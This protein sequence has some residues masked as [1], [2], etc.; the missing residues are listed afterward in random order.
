MSFIVNLSN[1]VY[2]DAGIKRAEEYARSRNLDPSKFRFPWTV[3][4]S[5][6][7]IFKGNTEKYPHFLFTDTLFIPI[8][9]I[10]DP[11]QLV[12][13]EMRYLGDNPN[14]T[15]YMKIKNSSD[16]FPLYFTQDLH[17]IPQDTPVIVTEGVMDAESIRDLGMPIISPLT[18]LQG[19]KWA[20]FLYAVSKKVF[21]AYDNDAGGLKAKDN[22]L[23]DLGEDN[24][25][26]NS[27]KLLSYPGK[28]L[29]EAIKNFGKRTILEQIKNQLLKG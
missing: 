6:A 4:G 22:F 28:D 15:R 27:F 10:E 25:L 21:I 11:T 24:L 17:T 20:L 18:A 19:V 12:A 29:N 16:V 3:S 9:D 14:R 26:K 1:L 13:F 8:V 7:S 23:K 5:D 2:S